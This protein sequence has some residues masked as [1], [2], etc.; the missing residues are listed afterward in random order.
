MNLNEKAIKNSCIGILIVIICIL[1]FRTCNLY[2]DSRTDAGIRNAIER[3]IRTA[4]YFVESFNGLIH[5]SDR[6]RINNQQLRSENTE[7]ERTVTE[8]SAVNS[9]LR[10]YRDN[11]EETVNCIIGAGNGIADGIDGITKLIRAIQETAET[12]ID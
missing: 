7:L 12:Q 4:Q 5:E 6:I 10:K 1:L 8:L 9:E 2:S 11:L 3:S